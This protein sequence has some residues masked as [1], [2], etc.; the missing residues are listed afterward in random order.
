MALEDTDNLLV[1]RGTQL[2]KVS[3]ENMAKIQD[4][5]LLLIARGSTN[6]KIRGEDFNSS[7]V[8][9]IAVV[10]PTII[11]PA[12]GA[13]MEVFP[14]SPPVQ[15][16]TTG[17]T[18]PSAVV[19]IGTNTLPFSDFAGLGFDANEWENADMGVAGK[20]FIG[21][22]G[23]SKACKFVDNI[24]NSFITKTFSWSEQEN[25]WTL[26]A[27][28]YNTGVQT[29]NSSSFDTIGP[30]G[31]SGERIVREYGGSGARRIRYKDNS[32]FEDV[33]YTCPQDE[34]VHIRV[35]PTGFH[36]N[37]G[38]LIPTVRRVANGIQTRLVIGTYA[39]SQT[40]TFNGYI[41]PMRLVH[42]DLGAPPAG[43]LETSG[44]ILPQGR[45]VTIEFD[46]SDGLSDF[47]VGDMVVRESGGALGQ[48]ASIGLTSF[49]LMNVSGTFNPGDILLGPGKPSTDA[50]PDADGLIL[51]GSQFVTSEGLL[52]GHSGSTWQVA[53]NSD[54]SFSSPVA[55]TTNDPTA[56][57]S[58]SVPGLEAETEYRARCKYYADSAESAFSDPVVFKTAKPGTPTASPGAV[59]YVARGGTALT[60]VT[61]PG[62][63][64][65]NMGQGGYNGG[66][67]LCVGTDG[68][69]YAFKIRSGVTKISNMPNVIATAAT[70]AAQF[71]TGGA[72]Y[73]NY[74]SCCFLQEDGTANYIR[75]DGGGNVKSPEPFK[76]IGTFGTY[77]NAIW[78]INAD[79][80]KIYVEGNNSTKV[81][82][83]TINIGLWNELTLNGFPSGE[84]IK[85][86][87]SYGG[88]NYA[89]YSIMILME[90]G[91]LY[92]FNDGS[93]TS[94]VPDIGANTTMTE[95][96]DNVVAIATAGGTYGGSQG[97]SALRADGT[98]WWASENPKFNWGQVTQLGSGNKSPIFGGY[99]NDNTGFVVGSDGCYYY[100][101]GSTTFNKV[102]YAG[103]PEV[104]IASIGNSINACSMDDDTY[105]LFPGT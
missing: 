55:Q 21:K 6:Y 43:G 37:G 48:I 17:S 23:I 103:L 38:S 4:D 59:H 44:G 96:L 36:I 24:L 15:T 57:L 31:S 39:D 10:N 5:D 72:D 62:V 98:V 9:P 87:C 54:T 27:Y 60:E 2:H 16:A 45:T 64:M 92:A 18:A 52:T 80:T 102:N 22:F 63:K 12:D 42:E 105:L 93:D 81:V 11:A 20:D 53:A 3:I 77:V 33:N 14:K 50:A 1:Q 7:I 99:S 13:G 101:K 71:P 85:S 86:V 70:T 58:W 51:Q 29:S 34:W 67:A 76:N 47:A 25:E 97:F 84:V 95:K 61:N 94:Q 69:A 88:T 83:N 8:P 19:N 100:F 90:S 46:S 40:Y 89:L 30:T 74:R 66:G 104:P 82:N 73:S 32:G 49:E 78:G 91:K 68:Y 26:D 75:H 28:I 79:G 35:R 65:V 56:L 41:G